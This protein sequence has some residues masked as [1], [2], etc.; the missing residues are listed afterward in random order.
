M[1]H[2]S[3]PVATERGAL[4][5]DLIAP[6]HQDRE[7]RSVTGAVPVDVLRSYRASRPTVLDDVPSG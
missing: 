6:S 3:N 5:D 2:I 1:G 4:V 7:T